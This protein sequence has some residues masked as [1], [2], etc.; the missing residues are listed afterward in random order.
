MS[1]QS[2]LIPNAV[3]GPLWNHWLIV[4]KPNTVSSSKSFLFISGGA[5]D[6]RAPNSGD[7]NMSKIAVAT[8][9]I[10]TELRMVPNQPLVFSGETERRTED[11]FIAYTWDKFL[12]TQDPK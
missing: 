3:H 1:S 8:K 4:V 10:V 9:S 6:G 5:N 11:S 2:W 12:R 7:G